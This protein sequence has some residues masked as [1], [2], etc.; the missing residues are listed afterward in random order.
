MIK[1]T[2]HNKTLLVSK[3]FLKKKKKDIWQHLKNAFKSLKNHFIVF[4]IKTFD[5]WSVFR[6]HPTMF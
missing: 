2:C 1:S 6:V 4:F 5:M 3:M